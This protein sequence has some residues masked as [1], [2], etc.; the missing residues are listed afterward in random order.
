M[1][2]HLLH[3][4]DIIGS[5]APED[6]PEVLAFFAERAEA[7]EQGL[8]EIT[9]PREKIDPRVL[10]FENE[11]NAL[12]QERAASYGLDYVPPKIIY[13][14]ALLFGK[15]AEIAK[16]NELI[17]ELEDIFSSGGAYLALENLILVHYHTFGDPE[18]N[19][20]FTSYLLR[21]EMGHAGSVKKIRA[22][23]PEPGVLFTERYRL[24]T[25]LYSPKNG[26]F[27][28]GLLEGHNSLEDEQTIGAYQEKKWG[29]QWLSKPVFALGTHYKT[30]LSKR[31]S[32]RK[33]LISEDKL[34][35]E[36]PLNGYWQIESPEGKIFELFSK[37][38]LYFEFIE[39]MTEIYDREPALYNLAEDFIYGD[40][41]IAFAKKADEVFWRGFFRELMS[42]GTNQQALQLLE[43]IQ[44]QD[45]TEV[46]STSPTVPAAH[47]PV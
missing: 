40:K 1:K 36:E 11:L 22:S 31:E 21:H 39:L 30:A 38:E 24:G 28:E 19:A 5:L 17:Q 45:A 27:G 4:P 14:D 8:Q 18:I 42:V 41:M 26:E 20:Y 32:I 9:F 7:I 46:E 33:R 16:K 3:Q 10:A 34:Q 47:R 44:S 43:K 35:P 23:E 29:S 37:G 15:I 2:E 25:Y 6:F 12:N 13:I